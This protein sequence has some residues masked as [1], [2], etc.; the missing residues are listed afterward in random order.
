MIKVSVTIH[1]PLAEVWDKWISVDGVQ[2]WAF[3][4]DDW[5]AEGIENNVSPKLKTPKSS[6]KN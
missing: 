1:A 6:I 4:S 5:A 3:A 2:H